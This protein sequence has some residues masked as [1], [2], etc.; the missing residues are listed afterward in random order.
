V[1]RYLEE[2]K[3][4]Y[5]IAGTVVPIVPGAVLMDLWFGGKSNIRPNADC[6]YRAASSATDG[7]VAEG[8]VGAGAGSTVGKLTGNNRAMK[9]G[10]GTAAI[11]FPNG[12]VV[13]GAC[14]GERS[15]IVEPATGAVVA[16]VRTADGG[17]SR[18]HGS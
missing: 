4:G 8:N 10:I 13:A 15:D 7:P 12:L 11:T 1:S 6:G 16:G 18:T 5:K 3:V 14:R 9:A 17:A 2:K